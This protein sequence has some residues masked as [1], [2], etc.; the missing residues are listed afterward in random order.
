MIR[1]QKYCNLY[2]LVV[3]SKNVLYNLIIRGF[4]L[5]LVL[6]YFDIF[7]IILKYGYRH[8]RLTVTSTMK[9]FEVSMKVV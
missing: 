7:T 4:A 1:Q 6:I 9:Y 8:I 3:Y 2:C 5:P